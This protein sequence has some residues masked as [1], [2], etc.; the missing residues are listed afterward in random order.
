MKNSRI[1]KSIMLK[2]GPLWKQQVKGISL[3]T[4]KRLIRRIIG[5][6]NLDS[7]GRISEDKKKENKRVSCGCYAQKEVF[8]K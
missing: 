6:K 4:K 5:S 1:S 7:I 2:N 3:C 8:L